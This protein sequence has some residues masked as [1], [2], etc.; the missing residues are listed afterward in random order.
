MIGNKTDCEEDRVISED[1]AKKLAS[2][3]DVE[4]YETSAQTGENVQFVFERMASSLLEILQKKDPPV[5][6]DSTVEYYQGN[7]KSKC[8]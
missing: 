2:Q 3:L 8:C 1:E 7:K 4:Y 6:T 5:Y